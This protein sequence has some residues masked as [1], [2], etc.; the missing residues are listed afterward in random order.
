L[1]PTVEVAGRSR[2]PRRETAQAAAA[3]RL[4]AT[5]PALS[6]STPAPPAS[7]LAAR[8]AGR[9]VAPP[10]ACLAALPAA[11]LAAL[12]LAALV[13]ASAARAQAPSGG[14][15]PTSPAPAP[16][17]R[18]SA[19]PRL[20]RVACAGDC[21]GRF[22]RAGSLL[23]LRGRT[24]DAVDTVVFLGG[25]DPADDVSVAPVKLRARSLDARVPRAAVAGAVQL[26]T[27]DGVRSAPRA[28][29]LAA[30]ASPV[31]AATPAI[32]VELTGERVFYDSRRPPSIAFT[33]HDSAPVQ[34]SVDLVRSADGVPVAHWGPL[35]VAPEAPQSIAWDG[36]A[37]GAVQLDGRYQFRVT[38]LNQAGVQASI[39]QLGAAA[40]PGSFVFLDQMFPVRGAHTFGTGAAA[41][42][43]GRGHQGQDVFAACGT[44][45][46]AARGGVVQ[47]K[48]YDGRGGNYLVIDGDGTD[49]D[50]AYMHLREPALVNKGA[51]VLTGQ[52]IGYV[53]DTGD[54]QG[55]HLHFEMWSAP[56]WYEGGAP[57]DP[58]PS[59]KTWD[60]QS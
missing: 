26:V 44:P 23:R 12:L 56:G 11:F 47:Y 36:T 27:V 33:V 1:P 8:P 57:F 17:A 4:R 19:P 37:A 3:P 5:L 2:Q 53:G 38:A 29:Q 15:A 16:A 7:T 20:T 39:S 59:L 48:A 10:A 45:L 21:A 50:Y 6:A 35:Q 41:F 18:P 55:C 32:D 52:L 24:L 30:G 9:R 14:T 58:L 31:S 43:G 46:V 40:A 60:R 28:L 25:P 22:A 42:G 34:V 49:V 54:A 13:L 51:H